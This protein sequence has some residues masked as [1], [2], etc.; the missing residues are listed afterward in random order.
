MKMQCKIWRRGAGLLLAAMMAGSLVACGGGGGSNAGAPVL[1]G[2]GG[3]GGG[4]TA[5]YAVSLEI[6]R[7]GAPIT[8]VSSAETVQAVATVSTRGGSP[9]SG[10][11]VTFSEGGVG[12]LSFQPQAATALTDVNGKASVDLGAKTLTG[13]GATTVSAAATVAGVAVSG[14]KSIAITASA[15]VAP[16]P[17]AIS[18]VSSSA[19]G[20]AIVVKGTGG[21]GRAE[22]AILEFKVLDAFGAPINGAT[23]D[24][25][26]NS[27]SGGAAISP[28]SAISDSSG[29]VTTTVLSGNAPASI[30]VTALSGGVS[31][32]SDTLLV[33]NSLPVQRGFE[34]VAEKYNLDGGLT[35][36]ST[37]LSAFIRDEFGNLVPDGVAVSFLTDYGA[38]ASSTQGGCTSVNGRCT[39]DFRVQNPRGA[40]IATVVA[41]V[42]VGNST[43]LSQSLRINMAMGP[44]FAVN[45]ITGTVLNSVTMSSCKQSFEALLSD[46][47][48]RS[49]AAGTSIGVNFISLGDVAV[50]VKSGTPVFDQLTTFQPSTFGFEVDMSADKLLPKCRPGGALPGMPQAYFKLRFQTPG[51][52]VYEQR[53]DVSYPQ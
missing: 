53:V 3:S 52:N 16:K 22:S 47:N 37:K 6:A 7:G 10:V 42:R 33:S 17:A 44:Y 5:A 30:V 18:F 14:S 11:V 15:T 39:A 4:T 28:A 13:T 26:M 32:Q 20:Q 45:P 51:G 9:V 29:R 24:F 41:T 43:T 23:V 48:G 35:G 31:V 36:D 25:S 2:S 38:V 40:G 46:G 21:T 49:V 1:D 27:N 8:Q 12:L 34:I 19:Q 50:A